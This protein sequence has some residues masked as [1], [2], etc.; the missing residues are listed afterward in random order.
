MSERIDQIMEYI[1]YP[2]YKNNILN[3]CVE[4]FNNEQD[5]NEKVV[6]DVFSKFDNSSISNILIKVI[7]LNNRYSAGLNDNPL[8]I[9]KRKE[10]TTDNKK[11]PVDVTTMAEHIY[12]NRDEF[13]KVK[14]INEVIELVDI[15][16]DIEGFQDAYSFA[17]K[18]CSWT[19]SGIDVP[20]VDSYVK[21]LLYRLNVK[22]KFDPSFIR[23]NQ[24][25][26]YSKY[27]DIY[28]CFVDTY[29]LNQYSYK[30]VDKY[31]WQYAKNMLVKNNMDIRIY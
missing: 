22:Y 19:Y 29:H 9:E 13:N 18:Y 20:I 15:M 1:V 25:N 2:D 16:R 5:L 14:K 23:Q 12:R 26:D 7:V 31:L 17:T 3:K 10:Y 21:G 6:G 11:F 27:L 8:S 30:D 24:L 4:Q 28:K